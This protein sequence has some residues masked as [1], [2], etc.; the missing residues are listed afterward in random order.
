[1]IKALGD[2]GTAAFEV[3]PFVRRPCCWSWSVA[4]AASSVAA[5]S[6]APVSTA[7]AASP[8]KV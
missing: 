4:A 6:N 1:V 2:G 8:F 5:G 3:R 7:I